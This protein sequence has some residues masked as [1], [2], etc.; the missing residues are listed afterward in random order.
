M[1]RFIRPLVVVCCLLM[2]IPA[3][4]LAALVVLQVPAAQR[5]LADTLSRTL[6]QPPDTRIVIAGL[7]VAWP[8]DATVERV[9]F[10]DAEGPWLSV[11]GLRFDWSPLRLLSGMLA[12]ERLSADR[13]TMRRRPAGGA[14]APSSPAEQVRRLSLPL[15]LQI[16]SIA[17]PVHLGEAVAGRPV[18]AMVD[19]N[20]EWAAGEVRMSLRAAETEGEANLDAQLGYS[21]ADGRLR[22]DI[23]FDEPASRLMAS[24]FGVRELPPMAVRLRGDGPLTG[25]RG[26][27]AATS[28]AETCLEADLH[29]VRGV[30]LEMATKG[31]IGT[32]CL[33]SETLRVLA[34][35][36]IAFDMDM[37]WTGTNRLHIGGGWVSMAAGNLSFGGAIVDGVAED[38]RFE[39]DIAELSRIGA[40]AGID[41]TGRVH[42]S[43]G[44]AGELAS[45][46]VKTRLTS[47]AGSAGG[48]AWD[49]LD[50][51]VSLERQGAGWIA[52]SDGRVILELPKAYPA[53][54]EVF[55]R[56]GAGVDPATELIRLISLQLDSHPARLS[57]FGTVGGWGRD[58]RLHLGLRGEDL[59]QLLAPVGVAAGGRAELQ[60]AATGNPRQGGLVL[61]GGGGAARL[62][63]GAGQLDTLLG[64]GPRVWGAAAMGAGGMPFTATIA[65]AQ[66]TM[67]AGG[68]AG[69][70]A[71]I[72]LHVR[73]PD[74]HGLGLGGAASGMMLMAGGSG[75]LAA[76]GMIEASGLESGGVGRARVRLA[77]G[78]ADI[79]AAPEIR[80]VAKGSAP[81]IDAE[82]RAV[83]TIADVV[84]IRNLTLSA[85]SD[86]IAGDL[87]Y[88]PDSGHI[89]G[90]LDGRVEN[91]QRW[92]DLA[93]LPL[94]G[95]AAASMRLRS[96]D[97][98]QA[99]DVTVE[100]SHLKVAD[101][102]VEKVDGRA[103]LT[104]V[105]DKPAGR[106]AITA[107]NVSQGGLNI[108]TASLQAEGALARFDFSIEAK[109][110]G[111]EQPAMTAGG[112]GSVAGA[113]RSVLLRSF[114]IAFGNQQARLR[115]PTEVKW[116]PAGVT[117]ASTVLAG[118]SGDMMVAGTLD[119]HEVDA[120]LRLNA[121]PLDLMGFVF[122]PDLV[123]T[124]SG[125]ATIA[126]R[127]PSPR[128]TLSLSG[129]QVG[130]R[131]A[132][133]TAPRLDVEAQG[134]WD[135]GRARLALRAVSGE[136]VAVRANGTFPLVVGTGAALALPPEEPIDGELDLD[137][138]LARIAD[139]LPLADQRL[140]GQVHAALAV[141]GTV[142]QPEIT[143]TAR[144]SQGAYENYIS[145]TSLRDIAATITAADFRNFDVV[146]QA[147]DGGAGRLA[148]QG[149]ISLMPEGVGYQ[150]AGAVSDF[151]LVRLDA[152]T[153]SVSGDLRLEG[154]DGDAALN[155][156]LKVD[157]ADID[158]AQ[159]L[160]AEVV[161]LDVV[162]VNRP[163]GPREPREPAA[164]A[165]ARGEAASN[166]GLDVVVQ[167][168]RLFVRGSGLESEWQGELTVGGT[169]SRPSVVGEMGIVRGRYEFIGRDF[170]LTEGHVMFDGGDQINPNL[171]IVA[172]SK[173]E[174]IAARVN[175]EGDV[176]NPQIAFS[177]DPPYPAD[178]IL[179]RLMF[180]K[181]AGQLTVGQQVGLARAA[182]AFA[183]GGG[184]FD[185]IGGIRGI[186][187]LDVLE[188]GAGEQENGGLGPTVSA[189]KYIDEKT[190]LRLEQ[191]TKGSSVAIERDLGRG[192]SVETEVGQQSGSGVGLNWRKD[193]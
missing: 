189:G 144:V 28:Q 14:V 93:G 159:A 111:P 152:A 71:T 186:L 177:S 51:G 128:V 133:G 8:L 5:M 145:G 160:P 55:W 176:R 4:L 6:S 33:D 102:A 142:A 166:L 81:G 44:V 119:G 162:E 123:G 153:A 185:P 61:V 188:V 84:A 141:A 124:V 60:L 109:G 67:S 130:V 131:Q 90:T 1:R 178:E 172:E 18:V 82:A 191:G 92:S 89:A 168:P 137:A 126:G 73:A 122:G 184:G 7:Q 27:L 183:G 158:I 101:V 13:V 77:V 146:G 98:G 49:G 12:I 105:L 193:Y 174:G 29:L 74:L 15:D 43:G 47:A 138:E 110:R 45:P 3:L 53:V 87:T 31:G 125:E 41:M 150:L 69:P 134:E 10:V 148:I 157:R 155:G 64:Q 127:L 30:A 132:D 103:A 192:L 48:V 115:R 9:D 114:E 164:P 83:V 23:G 85:G 66:G 25:W 26:R 118:R 173:A 163:G 42:L 156:A 179:S 190:F 170:R 50:G 154:R 112:Q 72:G 62:T 100:A 116:G 11:S 140:S 2:A 20:G 88:Q 167:V 136:R 34:P 39:I 75:G 19:G 65:G 161:T 129:S 37:A 76:A 78:A 181:E 35:D 52:A 68:L 171:A 106:L 63:T 46:T 32:R 70:L 24:L 143:G 97:G 40:L 182:A 99:M 169:A 180:G 121:V 165:G 36:G 149:R 57:A 86:R 175:V 113:E 91:L 54:G 107:S 58:V 21:E 94:A 104:A 16:G 135:K 187:G 120:R 17:A 151:A 96:E 59:G 108:A 56:V 95:S 22:V 147:T 139:I 80:V 38:L 117:L 79:L